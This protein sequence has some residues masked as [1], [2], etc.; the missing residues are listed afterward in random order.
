MNRDDALKKIK[1]CL[2]L[3]RSGEAHE[4]AA[5]MRQA[6]KL[7]EQFGLHDHDVAL[8]DIEEVAV[9]ASCTGVNAWEVALVA[10]IAL[11]FGCEQYTSRRSRW[12]SAGNYVTE[13][14]Y[15][16]VGLQASAQVAGYA[17]EVLGRQCAKARLGHIAKQPK[18]CKPITKTARG[19]A[20]AKGWVASV[21]DMVARFSQPAG[22][23]LLLLAYMEVK[24][25]DMT[26]CT[27]SDKSQARK[28][29]WGHLAAGHKAGQSATLNRGM[30]GMEARR[31]LS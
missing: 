25:P 31:L 12:N 2:A 10:M 22:D 7:M 19:D 18:N 4:A 6:Q 5:A 30:G 1:K 9:K 11:A 29:D 26:E 8:S 16:F 13:R 24:H 20:F 14:L 15:V 3:G 23:R 27:V 28:T 21:R 17:F